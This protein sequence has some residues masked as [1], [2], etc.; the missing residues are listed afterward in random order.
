LD[1]TQ[2]RSPAEAEPL[3]AGMDAVVT[4]RLHG[5]LLAIKNRVRALAIDPSRMGSKIKR[6]A[7]ALGR[8]AINAADRPSQDDLGATLEFCLSEEGSRLARRCAERG[9]A[10]LE[11]LRDE[12]VAALV[13]RPDRA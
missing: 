10:R 3:I 8:P 12:F 13:E 9:A 5:L 11:S 6:Q 1:Q 7:E 4:T 2:L